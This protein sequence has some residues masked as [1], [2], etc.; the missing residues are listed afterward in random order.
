MGG[1]CR[2][3]GALD[4]IIRLVG[5][6]GMCR[7][8]CVRLSRRRGLALKALTLHLLDEAVHSGLRTQGEAEG[9]WVAENRLG[10]L[11]ETTP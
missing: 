8:R 1:S 10:Q 6:V 11:C 7:W 9:P 5:E 3:R 2:G 4:G